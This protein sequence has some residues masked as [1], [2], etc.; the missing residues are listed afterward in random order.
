MFLLTR[1]NYPSAV[2][3]GDDMDQSEK[4]DTVQAKLPVPTVQPQP[5][6]APATGSGRRH[7]EE[8][9]ALFESAFA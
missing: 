9:R 7:E 8:Q 1:K 2:A 5:R 6:D 4:Q 3:M